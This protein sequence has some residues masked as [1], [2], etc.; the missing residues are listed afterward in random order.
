MRAQ[1]AGL[2]CE[3]IAGL[4]YAWSLYSR[5]LKAAL[6][7]EVAETVRFRLFWPKPKLHWL[8]LLRCSGRWV[9]M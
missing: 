1:G 7:P 5:Y 2:A 9:L 4:K 3:A 6:D 8:Y